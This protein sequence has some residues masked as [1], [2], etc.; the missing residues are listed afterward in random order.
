[1][2]HL[3]RPRKVA[4]FVAVEKLYQTGHGRIWED[5]LLIHNQSTNTMPLAI[6]FDI[7]VAPVYTYNPLKIPQIWHQ[8]NR[9]L[10]IFHP[11]YDSIRLGQENQN[12][13]KYVLMRPRPIV[14][15]IFYTEI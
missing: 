6:Q 1:M 9:Q 7:N 5:P 15:N 8:K 11:I 4:N 14:E 10:M 13:P 2:V 12:G 3:F